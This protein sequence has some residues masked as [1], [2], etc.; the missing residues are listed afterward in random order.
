MKI[1]KT[2]FTVWE[3]RHE[4][5]VETIRD[6]YEL[7][8][9][10]SL[11]PIDS[12]NDTTKGLQQIIADAIVKKIPLR[13][14][15]AGW[16]WTKIATAEAGI[17]LD[18]KPLNMIFDISG[19][20]VATSYKGDP[21]K[22]FLAQCGNG[23]WELSR[24]LKNR[25]LSLKTSGASNGQT[26]A[27]VIAT[28][29]H[30]SAFDVG[31]VQDFV[32]GLHIIVSPTRHIW[33]ERKSYPVVSDNLIRS[34]HTEL[35][36]DDDLFYSA[37]VSFGSFG[38]IHGA[39]I[40]TESI[41][42]LEAYMS[43]MPFD[44]SLQQIMQTLDFTNATLPYGS[45][46]PFH[47]AV[48][49]NPYDLDKGAYV[50]TMYKRPYKTG[51]TPPV[52]N[53]NGLGPGD[54]A[55]C[56]IGKITQVIPSLVPT[57]VTKLLASSLTPYSRQFGTMGEIF[58]NTTLHGKLLSAAIGIPISY[59]SKATELLLAINKSNGPF[60]GL[61]AYRFVKKSNAKLAFTKFDYTCVLELD[62]AFS[63]ETYAFYT[64][65]WKKFEEE[66]IPFAFHWGK[67]NELDFNRL[68][69]IYGDDLKTWL[70]SR[71]KLLDAD[72][73]RVFTNATLTKWGL[74]A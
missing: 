18:T 12:Y 32:V 50:T 10:N 39:M 17:M 61:F 1:I 36:Q 29:A 53:L 45:E 40:E 43:T 30:G 59:V 4:T 13:A 70:A 48:S 64:A 8:N 58:D 9:D 42:L 24:F 71:N 2:G 41:F 46:R 65:V 57:L 55:P 3:N 37:L 31:A 56:F 72:S 28:G 51:Y 54:D 26:I 27:G 66:K 11:P 69:N 20:S 21:T 62:A 35:V 49:L 25:S 33:L 68:S 52:R 63:D 67:I 74:D 44:A 38:I 16:S 19:P 7:G 60:A 15:G 14:L 22:L 23:V 34:L 47:F 73:K 5:F 6:L